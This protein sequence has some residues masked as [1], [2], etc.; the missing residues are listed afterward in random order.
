MGFWSFVGDVLNNTTADMPN[1]RGVV[2][3]G[4]SNTSGDWGIYCGSHRILTVLGRPWGDHERGE[5]VIIP[6]TVF[7]E[8]AHTRHYYHFIDSEYR[9]Y[10][11]S[12]GKAREAMQ[13]RG[14]HYGIS[15]KK[16]V[17]ELCGLSHLGEIERAGFQ[18]RAVFPDKF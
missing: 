2:T 14:D 18:R 15:S 17:A 9:R 6:D 11:I 12:E 1:A 3:T 7:I 10:C 8:F 5:I 4:L 16:F 13:R